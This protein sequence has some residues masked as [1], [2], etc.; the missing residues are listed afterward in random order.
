MSAFYTDSV[1]LGN[2]VCF[3][4]QERHLAERLTG[5]IH[6]QPG[7]NYPYSPES[8]LIAHIGKLIVEE[9]GLINTYYIYVLRQQ[10]YLL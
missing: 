5:I 10:Q 1:Q 7:Y 6:I 9:L 2:I 3:G 8:Q 4:Q